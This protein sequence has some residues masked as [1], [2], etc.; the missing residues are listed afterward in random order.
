MYEEQ[1]PDDMKSEYPS[2][3]EECFH[4]SLEGS[5][6]KRELQRARDDKRIGLPLPYDPSRL[7]QTF[8]DIGMD[9]ENCIW[10]HQTDGVRHRLIDFYSN[11]GEGLPHYIPRSGRTGTAVC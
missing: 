11:S 5:Y 1:G 8:W 10:F 6:F 3:I 7:V 4:S 9:D 2:C